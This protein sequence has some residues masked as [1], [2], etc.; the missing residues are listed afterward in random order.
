M[1]FLS[2]ITGIS[3]QVQFHM[4]FSHFL[5]LNPLSEDEDLLPPVTMMLIN[6]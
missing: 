6:K 3:H 4:N 2:L 1:T 5:K